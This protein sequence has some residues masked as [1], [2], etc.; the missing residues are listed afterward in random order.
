MPRFDRGIFLLLVER[1][2]RLAM[3][4]V[5]LFERNSYAFMIVSLARTTMPDSVTW[6]SFLSRS[7]S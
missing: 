2:T 4:C 3:L 5:S 6:N 7:R 1:D